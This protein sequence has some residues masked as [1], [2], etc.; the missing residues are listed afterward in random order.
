VSTTRTTTGVL[1]STVAVTETVST[2]VP[3][4]SD[5]AL[6]RHFTS[7]PAVPA[8]VSTTVHALRDAALHDGAPVGKA[9]RISSATE[10][11]S[12]APP[13]IGTCTRRPTNVRPSASVTDRSGTTT[14]V[15]TTL[16]DSAPAVT[17]SVST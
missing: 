16:A 14:I 7:P 15:S 5:V 10:S 4:A 6:R 8:G 11:R 13:P 9:S 17:T 1:P 3:A 12:A 2:Y